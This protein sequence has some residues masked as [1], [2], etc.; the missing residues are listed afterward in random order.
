MHMMH[1]SQIMQQSVIQ[2]EKKLIINLI[3]KNEI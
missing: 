3:L 2:H 1:T